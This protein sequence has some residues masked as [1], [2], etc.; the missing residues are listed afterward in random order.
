[1]TQLNTIYNITSDLNLTQ[2]QF[3]VGIK[4]LD[5]TYTYKFFI[6]ENGNLDTNII[7]FLGKLNDISTPL[8]SSN[9]ILNAY[10]KVMR[11]EKRK[12]KKLSKLSNDIMDLLSDNSTPLDISNSAIN[13]D[14]SQTNKELLIM[15]KSFLVSINEFNHRLSKLEDNQN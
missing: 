10:N 13:N 1:M 15:L 4:E 7:I 9:D 5:P 6:D 8:P 2:Q 12:I 14:M 3:F 11:N